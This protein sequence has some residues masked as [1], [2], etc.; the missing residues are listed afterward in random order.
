[1]SL[2]RKKNQLPGSNILHTHTPHFGVQS[3]EQKSSKSPMAVIMMTHLPHKPH[4]PHITTDRPTTRS[5]WEWFHS[6][7]G[8][9]ESPWDRE[10]PAKKGWLVEKSLVAAPELPLKCTLMSFNYDRRLTRLEGAKE[11]WMVERIWNSFYFY[12]HGIWAFY[13]R[14]CCRRFCCQFA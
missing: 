9:G 2:N 5:S 1:M 3:V 6:I 7:V 12:W 8:G 13:R 4:A 14:R 10:I 11:G